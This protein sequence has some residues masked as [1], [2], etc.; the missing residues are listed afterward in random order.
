MPEIFKVSQKTGEPGRPKGVEILGG[1]KKGTEPNIVGASKPGE[2]KIMS[3]N[4]K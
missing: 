3:R 1:S 2:P 4:E